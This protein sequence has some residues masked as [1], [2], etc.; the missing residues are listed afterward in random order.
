MG[1]DI[2]MEVKLKQISAVNYGGGL[3]VFAIDENGNF[4]HWTRGQWQRLKN[5]NSEQSSQASPKK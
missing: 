5:P 2:S 4:W 1:G 3:S